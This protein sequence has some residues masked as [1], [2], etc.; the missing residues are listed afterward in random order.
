MPASDGEIL[1]ELV[2][3]AESDPQMRPFRSLAG[4]SQYR[5]LYR[6][7][8]RYVPAGAK[9][10][11][12]G[13]GPGHF[14]YFLCRAG[15][16]ASGYS[17]EE[18]TYKDWLKNAPYTFVKAEG[19]PVK[20]PFED[21]SFDAVASVG[22]LEHVRET[23]GTEAGS[24]AEIARILCPG[25]VFICTHFPNRASLIDFAAS[26]V[27]GKHRHEFKYSRADI[28]KLAADARLTLLEVGRYG[29]LP[30]NSLASLPRPIRRSSFFAALYNG[31]DA[32]LG[33]V[34]SPFCQNYRFVARKP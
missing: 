31:L 32:A 25:G 16:R 23:G 5:S 10:L 18:F 11:D 24:L 4:A 22:V 20:I 9:V 33:F 17:F 3:I 19:D 30:R 14:S 29:F 15:Y 28:E 1:R 21:A 7:V 13:S 27:P 8:R 34:F 2:A 12:W 26:R 6:F